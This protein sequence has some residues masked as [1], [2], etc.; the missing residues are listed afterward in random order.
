MQDHL[1][2]LLQRPAQQRSD[3]STA[4]HIRKN[5]GQPE[6][7][8]DENAENGFTGQG[9]FYFSIYLFYMTTNEKIGRLLFRYTR[10]ELTDRE[11]RDLSAWRKFSAE[12]EK[13][14]IEETDPENMRENYI[15]MQVNQEAVL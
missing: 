3:C 8:G 10:G 1:S 11:K 5:R 7:A 13:A 4:G 9:K 12:N 2:T 14:F 6:G 15:L